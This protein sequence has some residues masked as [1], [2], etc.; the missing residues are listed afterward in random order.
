MYDRL[1]DRD[2]YVYYAPGIGERETVQRWECGRDA[3]QRE[4]ERERGR[5]RWEHGRDGDIRELESSQVLVK[6]CSASDGVKKYIGRGG[7][8]SAM[9]KNAPWRTSFCVWRNAAV[10]PVAHFLP[11]IAV[12]A[13]SCNT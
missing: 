9:V 7:T 12:G 1:S 6:E 10:L 3:T 13:G 4:R 11:E 8:V 2:S 5:E